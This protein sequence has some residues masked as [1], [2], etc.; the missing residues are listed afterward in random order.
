V[1]S[2]RLGHEVARL[3]I[4]PSGTRDRLTS[5]MYSGDSDDDGVARLDRALDISIAAEAIEQKLRAAAKAGT[6]DTHAAPGA[7]PATVAE[8]AVA[9][10]VITGEE[11]ETLALHR[12]AVAQVIRV[13]DF[14]ADLG[15]SL[16]RPPQPVTSHSEAAMQAPQRKVAA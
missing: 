10:G 7:D 12:E 15:T 14:D 9:A 5:G 3:L 4:E 1:P 2:D 16:L 11:A 13:D 8:R 6:L